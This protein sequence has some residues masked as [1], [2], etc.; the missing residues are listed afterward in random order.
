M[1]DRTVS[2]ST[3]VKQIAGLADADVSDWQAEFIDSIWQ[4]T[5]EGTK[6][7]HLTERQVAMIERIY[8]KHF[9]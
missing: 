1:T 5:D 4:K 9:A 6:T 8:R 2:I 3:M 7:S